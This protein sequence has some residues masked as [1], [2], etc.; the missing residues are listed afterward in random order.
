VSKRALLTLLVVSALPGVAAAQVRLGSEFRVNSYTTSNQN[1]PAIAAT[2]NGRFVV[3]WRSVTQDGS[4][5]G[6][7]ARRFSA[8]GAALGVEFQVNSY[9]TENQGYAAVTSD[10]NGNFVVVWQSFGQDGD[11]LGVF[12]RQFNA[13]GVPQGGEFQVNVYTTGLQGSAAVASDANGNFIVVWGGSGEGD[14]NGVFG[15]LYNFAGLAVSGPFVINAHTFGG[16]GSAAVAMDAN[17]NF[18]VVWAGSGAQDSSGIFARRYDASGTPLGGQF[19]VNSYTT[20]VQTRPSVAVDPS[21]GFVTVWQS[22][23]QDGSDRGVFGRRF[24]P[25]GDPAGP[26][27]DVNSYTTDRQLFPEVIGD[28]DGNFVVVWQSLGQDGSS[29]GV[30]ARRYRAS[31]RPAGGEFQVNSHTSASQG[32]PAVTAHASGDFVVVWRS[33]IQDGDIGGVY[34]Q[35]FAPD[36]IF[37]DGFEL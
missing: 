6:V 5:G 9:T 12:G 13:S 2:P 16:Q 14:S 19:L 18:V 10:A 1:S 24:T 11:H 35:R 33:D 27:F 29:D 3:V 37:A 28:A 23:Q 20:F 30:F 7:F 31:G 17:G 36:F 21:G 26:D 4:N 34:A 15:R 32:Y 25:V 8:A 22:D